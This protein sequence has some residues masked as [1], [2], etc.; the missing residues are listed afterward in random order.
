MVPAPFALGII[1]LITAVPLKVLHLECWGFLKDSYDLLRI[2]SCC[3]SSL[4][5]LFIQTTAYDH[6]TIPGDE[7]I[8]DD[9]R[10]VS[11]PVRVKSLR[12]LRLFEW[13]GRSPLPPTDLLE[14]PNLE[15]LELAPTLA[16]P[17]DIPSWI[18]DGLQELVLRVE[19]GTW[20]PDLGTSIRPSRLTIDITNHGYP[21][22]TYLEVM[23]WV[24]NSINRLPFPGALRHLTVRINTYLPAFEPL[25]FLELDD[26]MTMSAA[27]WQIHEHLNLEGIV[28]NIIYTMA[29]GDAMDLELP[30]LDVAFSQ[31][32][33]T[34]LFH[35][36]FGW[37]DGHEQS[38]MHHV[39]RSLDI[40]M[41]FL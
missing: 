37:S 36:T 40:S 18:P 33:D 41:P 23:A 14:C 25:H 21:N 20:M 17:W 1:S 5:D 39:F 26:Y 10:T 11:S 30:K 2:L 6:S 3:S 29:Q 35:V 27:L 12:I 24:E 31:L 19:P 22:A 16:G 34:G 8:V 28:V 9:G 38:L 15:R 7:T 13:I 32:L 4:E